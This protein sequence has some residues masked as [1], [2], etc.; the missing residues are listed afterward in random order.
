[1][2]EGLW[3]EHRFFSLGFRKLIQMLFIGRLTFIC[4]LVPCSLKTSQRIKSTKKVGSWRYVSETGLR[5][6]VGMISNTREMN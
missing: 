2:V 4:A 5:K 6:K 3:V 1:M